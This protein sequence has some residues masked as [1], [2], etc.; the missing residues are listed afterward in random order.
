MTELHVIRQGDEDG[1]PDEGMQGD[2]ETPDVTNIGAVNED[3]DAVQI[4]TV[5]AF[6]EL[7]ASFVVLLDNYRNDAYV[8]TAEILVD[9][10][11]G[12]QVPTHFSAFGK[13]S[14]YGLVREP[15]FK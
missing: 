1:S 7:E 11:S 10:L 15:L 4:L 3:L 13:T 5:H 12:A 8:D 14:R 9:R 2:T 6:R